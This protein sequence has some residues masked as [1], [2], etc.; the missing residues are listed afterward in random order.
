MLSVYAWVGK[1]PRA[2]FR[3]GVPRV[4]PCIAARNHLWGT[5]ARGRRTR[6]IRRR[7]RR[8]RFR[9][10]AL[11]RTGSLRACETGASSSASSCS[12][13]LGVYLF[14]SL[15]GILSAWRTTGWSEGRASRR[16][17]C[18]PRHRVWRLL[19]GRRFGAVSLRRCHSWRSS[20][21][22]RVDGRSPAFRVSCAHL[23]RRN[24]HRRRADQYARDEVRRWSAAR[25][26]DASFARLEG[27]SWGHRHSSRH[28]RGV[29]LA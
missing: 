12:S 20:S 5:G 11:P 23:V 25:V 22:C 16:R 6:T 18:R 7:S 9:C 27:V 3:G 15:P 17:R 26:T 28:F 24:A 8:L 4:D 10:E 1:S 14:A 29:A 13:S 21:R 19:A 2:S